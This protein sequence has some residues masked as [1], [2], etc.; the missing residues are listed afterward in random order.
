MKHKIQTI[1]FARSRVRVEVILTYLQEL[2]KNKI[3][4]KGIRG[5]RGGY[6]PT[7]RREIEKGLRNGEVY[8]VVSTNALELGVDIGQLQVCIMT[9]YP[10]TIASAWQQAGRAGRRNG[11]ALIIYVASSTPLDQYVIRHPEYFFKQSPEIARINPNNLIVLV[12]HIKCAA[13]ELRFDK[14]NSLAKLIL[15][16]C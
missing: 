11:E 9:G 3:G 5:Y 15:T 16:M 2:V 12:D 8:G 10:G 1:I 13:Y 14:M 6:L 4:A 7:E